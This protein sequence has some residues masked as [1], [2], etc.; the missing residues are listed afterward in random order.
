MRLRPNTYIT[1]GCRIGTV[2]LAAAA[3]LG[4]IAV[5]AQASSWTSHLSGAAPGF[6]SRRWTDSGGSTNIKF[7][8]CSDD[9]TNAHVAV[10]LRKDTFGP[11][12]SYVNASFTKCFA[13][14]SSTSSGTWDGHG[15]GD[16]YFVVN[17]ALVGVHVWV[18]SLTTTY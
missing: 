13:G 11:D 4:F 18:K 9:Y 10:R 1:P 6:E 16:Y 7:T 5:P 8:G 17:D 3:L 12:P 15:S 2:A 14:S